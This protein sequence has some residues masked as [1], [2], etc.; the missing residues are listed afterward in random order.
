M[1]L[2]NIS[3]RKY[4]VLE[5]KSEYDFYIKYSIV[6]N[7]SKDIFKLGDMTQR[8]FGLI[9]DIQYDLGQ[10]ELTWLRYLEYIQTMT[11]KSIKRLAL[12]GIV[13]LCQSHKYF[14]SEIQRII[15][16]ESIALEYAPDNKEVRAG[17][18]KL[19]DLAIYLQIRSIAQELNMTIKQVKDMKYEE[20]FVELVAQ[21]RLADYSKKY[22][23]I[24][25]GN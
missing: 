21:S 3:Y 1:S 11:G 4:A 14:I 17:I 7:T 18:N 20:A 19:D 16:I 13:E 2:K 12:L 10:G 25:A 8:S 15:E 5:D 24:N 6:C 9:K 23:K 22:M